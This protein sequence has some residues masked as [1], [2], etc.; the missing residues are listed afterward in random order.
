MT[1]LLDARRYPARQLA[2]LYSE[3]WEVETVFAEIK[4]HQRGARVVLSS[5]TPTASCNRSG[6]ICWSTTHCA[7]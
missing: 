6:H 4:T 2:A 5:K 7:N 1:S 3:R